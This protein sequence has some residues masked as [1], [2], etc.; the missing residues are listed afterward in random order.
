MQDAISR[1]DIDVCVCVI[2][3]MRSLDTICMHVQR[4]VDCVYR[5]LVVRVCVSVGR[6]GAAAFRK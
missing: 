6:V 5:N 2:R 4:C 3:N 1:F